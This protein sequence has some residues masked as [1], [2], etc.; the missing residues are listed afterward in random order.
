VEETV[1][2]LLLEYTE[3]RVKELEF[4]A[5]ELEATEELPTVLL[6]TVEDD[7]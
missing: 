7:W 1:V 5:A 2:E 3:D 6:G 4:T